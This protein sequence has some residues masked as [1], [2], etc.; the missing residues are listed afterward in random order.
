MKQALTL[1]ALLAAH[2]AHADTVVAKI[3]D[4]DY[5]TDPRLPSANPTTATAGTADPNAPAV[6][7]SPLDL[8]KGFHVGL[9][10]GAVYVPVS[11]A[12]AVVARA[13]LVISDGRHDI[14]LSPVLY[15][16]TQPDQSSTGFGIAVERCWNF[17]S[18][19][20]VSLGSMIGVHHADFANTNTSSST[21]L[22]IAVVGSPLTFRLGEKEN[23]ELGLNLMIMREFE[24]DT[25]NPGAYVSFS[26][27]SL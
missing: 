14:R 11:D 23:F 22:G 6:P 25:V 16:A 5:V 26:Y 3:E 18:R 27:L 12:T 1:A 4:P 8:R 10:F 15:H 17:S 20:S 7:A 2:T 21:T 19:Y 24:Y 9:S 13:N